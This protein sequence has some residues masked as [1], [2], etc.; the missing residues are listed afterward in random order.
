MMSSKGI[1]VPLIEEDSYPSKGD[2]GNTSDAK[3]I[4]EKIGS[5]LEGFEGN[6]LGEIENQAIAED[7]GSDG[8]EIFD[9]K[10][11][12]DEGRV[13]RIGGGVVVHRG[14][15]GSEVSAPNSI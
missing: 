8:E 11:E 10:V 5:G 12:L 13:D 6:Y 7:G 14:S 2:S 4:S 15:L 9:V 3:I 1:M